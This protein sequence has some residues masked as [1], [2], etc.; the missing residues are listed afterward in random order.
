MLNLDFKQRVVINTDVMGWVT[1]PAGG[2]LRKPLERAGEESGHVTSVVRYEKG[3]SFQRHFHPQGE[4]IFVLDGMFSDELGDY[5]KG[6]YIRNPPGSSH[7]PFSREG[8]TILVKLDQFADDD[9]EQIVIDTNAQLWLPSIAGIQVMPLHCHDEE[10]V[11]LVK[12]SPGHIFANHRHL[13]GEEMF[14]LSGCFRDEL[15]Y[16]PASTWLRNPHLSVHKP[17]VKEETVTWVKT[18]HL[19]PIE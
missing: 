17:F 14:I 19:W 8:C 3:A 4:E 2:V 16:Y 18:G 15:G 12:W 6:S 5:G 7:A 11:A 9:S 1:S 10:H 13:G